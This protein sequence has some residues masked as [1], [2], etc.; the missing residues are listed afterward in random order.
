[1]AMYAMKYGKYIGLSERQ[2]LE[3]LP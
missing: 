3:T 2:I 1:M